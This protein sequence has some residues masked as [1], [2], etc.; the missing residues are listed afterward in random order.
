MFTKTILLLSLIYLSFQYGS[1]DSH[2]PTKL[3]ISNS[4]SFSIY[5]FNLK[6]QTALSANKYLMINFT[7]YTTPLVP[8]SC[9]YSAYPSFPESQTTCTAPNLDSVLF[10]LLPFSVVST[11]SYTFVIELENP[12]PI[13]TLGSGLELKTVSSTDMSSYFV[14]DYNPNFESIAYNTSISNKMSANLVGF[15]TESYNLPNNIVRIFFRVKINVDLL[16]KPRIK[17]V[18]T[19]PWYFNRINAL[20]VENDPNYITLLDNDTIKNNYKAPSLLSYKFESPLEAYLVFNENIY[21]GKS[22]QIN[23]L[24]FVNPDVLSTIYLKIY[25][26]NYNSNSA[27]EASE[28]DIQLQ[29]SQIPL[30]VKMRLLSR[31]PLVHDTPGSFYKSSIQYIQ[32]N[33]TSKQFIPENY[34]CKIIVGSFNEIVRGSVFLSGL[35]AYNTSLP[36]ELTYDA[37]TLTISNFKSISA[38]K[39]FFITMRI[40][41]GVVASHINANVSID[42]NLNPVIPLFSGKSPSY[43]FQSNAYTIIGAFTLSMDPTNLITFSITPSSDDTTLNSYLELYFSRF[44]KFDE[45]PICQI[46]A[47]SIIAIRDCPVVNSGDYN[48]LKLLSGYNEN[49]FPSSGVTVSITGFKLIDPSN[50]QDKIYEFYFGLHR[51]KTDSSAKLFLMIPVLALPTRDSLSD[52]YQSISNN[53]CWTTLDYDYPSVINFVGTSASFSEISLPIG[54]QI[55]ITVFAYQ[56]FKNLLGTNVVS[57]SSFPC[58]SN[59]AITCLYFEGESQTKITS[60][61][62]LDW[63]RVHIYLPHTISSD[64]H[65]I[66]PDIFYCGSYTY[67]IYIGTVN[68]S[69]HFN[70]LYL[71]N[72]LTISPTNTLTS[73]NQNTNLII[74]D[75]GNAAAEIASSELTVYTSLTQIGNDIPYFGSALFIITD[76]Q[77]WVSG[78]SSA[79]GDAFGTLQNEPV[80]FDFIAGDNSH[81]FVLYLPL[82]NLNN[83]LNSGLISYLNRVFNP[84]SLDLP[85]Y[86]L[87]VTK[88]TGE[89]DIYNTLLN[90][91]I[92]S[93]S[94]TELKSFSF[95]CL[96]LRDGEKN[97]FCWVIFQANNRLASD[98]NLRLSS[99][100][101]SFQTNNCSLSYSKALI[102]YE[103]SSFVCSFVD[104]NSWNLNGALNLNEA[105]SVTKIDYF[106]MSFYVDIETSGSETAWLD[107]SIRDYS[108]NYILESHSKSIIILPKLLKFITISSIILEYYS[109]HSITQMN[110]TVIFPRRVY[111]NEIM[112]LD[113]GIDLFEKNFNL[114]GIQAFFYNFATKFAYSISVRIENN[115]ITFTLNNNSDSIPVGS[116]IFVLNGIQLPEKNPDTLFA[117]H[118]TRNL[119]KIKTLSSSSDSAASFPLLV[120]NSKPNIRIL[121]SK[122]MLESHACEFV[123][124]VTILSSSLDSKTKIYINFPPYHSPSLFNDP[125]LLYCGINDLQVNCKTDSSFP[126]RLILSDFPTFLYEGSTFNITVYGINNP[127]FSNQVLTKYS[128]K[129]IVFGVDQ[130]KNGS[131]SEIASLV[132]PIVQS[133]PDQFNYLILIDV[134]VNNLVIKD[135]SNHIFKMILKDLVIPVNSGFLTNFGSEYNSLEN[136]NSILCQVYYYDE[137]GT[138]VI[139]SDLGPCEV[140]GKRVKVKFFKNK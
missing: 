21:Q 128:N 109:P 72:Q 100:V 93:F 42:K 126:Y 119:D 127:K 24:S 105:L 134:F 84:F 77:L 3:S 2:L 117:V 113:I 62:F 57:N 27:I 115:F 98:G 19:S 90:S 26:M 125:A 139:V 87:Y 48:Y 46:I 54:N 131:F 9:F 41:T 47:P 64:F 43:N 66:L 116:Y 112:M 120:G 53:L 73:D 8:V 76:W 30:D 69:N 79:T 67:E 4:G 6:F 35:K 138:N 44:I 56:G 63:D 102:S 1:I 106:N 15:D 11:K 23:I 61:Y 91:G 97:T 51:D 140:R 80:S 132:P 94:S 12:N 32:I 37:D 78:T 28:N 81:R 137:F 123:F 85:N 16:E 52:F 34:Y 96:D 75:R 71:E 110:L 20:T 135:F 31:I 99:D 121:E 86:S 74:Q 130:L 25:S 101:M 10:F 88:N 70:Y 40:R 29:T 68:P 33:I 92:N 114:E 17:L 83:N 50:H 13:S 39:I 136:L 104:S 58:V 18:L 107:F 55:I 111:P 5:T 60:N 7:N 103:L 124:E 133:L 22:F 14:Y 129:S 45:K 36:L 118:F 122:Y 59:L 108:N 49:F 82:V 89:F 38:N 65:I 95:E